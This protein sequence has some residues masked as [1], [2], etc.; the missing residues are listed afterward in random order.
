M[1]ADNLFFKFDGE[2]WNWFVEASTESGVH[3]LETI[4]SAFSEPV[5][6]MGQNINL[7]RNSKQYLLMITRR[8][9][10]YEDIIKL[11][12]FRLLQCI[13]LRSTSML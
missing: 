10:S 13:V 8:M 7:Q 11:L 3:S 12:C 4:L 2:G 1:E 6:G 5:P 9:F